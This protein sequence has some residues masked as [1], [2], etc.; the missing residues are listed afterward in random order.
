LF[1]KEWLA[2]R[3]KLLAMAFIYLAAGLNSFNNW[4]SNVS[5]Y[6]AGFDFPPYPPFFLNSWLDI[7]QL[8]TLGMAVLAGAD[9]IAGE[10]GQGTIG[11]LLTKPVSR[12][13]VYLTKLAVNAGILAVTLLGNSLIMFGLDQLHNTRP[14]YANISETQAGIVAVIP[15]PVTT[16]G[17]AII[18]TL[19]LFGLGLVWLCLSALISIAVRTIIVTIIASL[20]TIVGILF[21]LSYLNSNY[22]YIRLSLPELIQYPWFTPAIIFVA[23]VFLMAGLL[24]FRRKEF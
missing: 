3:G 11:F 24:A 7:A 14:V 4:S 12:T 21:V 9:T 8:V 5:S 6:H 10:R 17:D 15:T 13:R 23:I 1:Y 2:V 16:A 20:V 22:V 18:T 19:A